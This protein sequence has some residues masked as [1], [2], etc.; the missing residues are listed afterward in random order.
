M[1]S[2]ESGQYTLKVE[3]IMKKFKRGS[4]LQKFN[5]HEEAQKGVRRLQGWN[6]H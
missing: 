6:H 5:Q 3:P 1:K 4:K 2:L